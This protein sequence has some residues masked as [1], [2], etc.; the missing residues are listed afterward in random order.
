MKL[1]ANVLAAAILL[2]SSTAHAAEFAEPPPVKT[3]EGS[4]LR[5]GSFLKFDEVVLP[6]AKRP[7]SD[8][9]PGDLKLA[10]KVWRMYL[11]GPQGRSALEVFKNYQ[12]ALTKAG[13][14]ILYS[15]KYAECGSSDGLQG[16]DLGRFAYHTRYLA[17][18]RSSPTGDRHV[19]L[20]VH[21]SEAETH[22]LIVE[23]KPIETGKVTVDAA[24][25]ASGLERDGHMA[26][27]GILFDTDKATL[28]PE[29]QK[30]LAAVADTLRQTPALKLYVIG[31]T[32][33]AG[34]LDRNLDLSRR[35]ATA[36][37]TEL[38]ATYK[39]AVDRLKA[40]GAGPYAPVAS[41]RS[42]SG[43]AQN[44]RVELVQQ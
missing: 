14:T 21:D 19:G 35:R 8:P 24:V 3:Y 23:S 4:I 44:R 30:A 7:E 9:R 38:V 42:E 18:K 15:C 20:T 36:V 34:A 2:L 29:S 11:D 31:H 32:D 28:K 39:I 41:N 37:V 13:Y 22:I 5:D 12:D 26:I 25:I 1:T 27:Y 40:D 43:R 17:A 10:G 16:T 33:N 6:T